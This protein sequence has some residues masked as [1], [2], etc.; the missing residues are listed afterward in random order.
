MKGTEPDTEFAPPSE[1]PPALPPADNG[2][3]IV[4]G[5]IAALALLLVLVLAQAKAAP[6]AAR[7]LLP[8]FGL[9][10]AAA[11]GPWIARRHPDETWLPKYLVWAMV[12]KLIAT[13][14]R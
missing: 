11:V 14:T 9:C 12:F 1:L 8:I 7:F 2:M 13:Y 6:E 4:F 5:V 10:A 3:A